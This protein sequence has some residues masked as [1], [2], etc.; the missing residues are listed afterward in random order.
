M[1]RNTLYFKQARLLVRILPIVA[2]ETC[3]ALKGGT[4]INLFVQDLPRLSVDIDLTYLPVED[5]DASLANI[6]AALARIAESIESRLA[7]IKVQK[8]G[9]PQD[10]G[11]RLLIQSDECRIKLELSPVLRGT[12]WPVEMREIGKKAEKLFGYA[13]MNVVSKA[14]L[15]AG[16]F[17]AALDR[18]HPRDLF[19]VK[20]FFEREGQQLNRELTKTF[21]VYLISHSRPISELLAPNRKNITGIFKQEFAAMTTVPVQLEELVQTREDLIAVV[22]TSF[23][24][25][26]RAFLRSFKC[27][28]PD[29]SLLDLPSVEVLPA[30]RW[31]LINLERMSE[32]KHQAALEKL[33]AVL[34]DHKGGR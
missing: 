10:E 28:S 8:P 33:N 9:A 5:R 3:F 17:C 34:N 23:T 19:D 22:H 1:N 15:Y 26:D 30:V 29:W 18:Q 4:A 11:L 12:V 21:L 20:Q 13:E 32:K 24:E 25:D 31:K 6:H 16:K 7:G 2:E 27:R 14:D